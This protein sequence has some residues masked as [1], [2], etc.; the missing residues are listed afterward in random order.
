MAL[1]KNIRQPNSE[2]ISLL[3]KYE[4]EYLKEIRS[5][6]EIDQSS[7]KE[8]IKTKIEEGK[9]EKFESEHDYNSYI[10]GLNDEL[11][12]SFELKSSSKKL[13]IIGLYM[14]VEKY[15]KIIVKWLYTGLDKNE[16]AEK[17][18]N[19]HRWRFL[20]EEMNREKITLS[21]VA[22][23]SKI[24][25]LRCLNNDIKHN[26]YVGEELSNFSTWSNDINKEID[27]E[28][29]D[30]DNFYNSMPKYLS[31]LAEKIRNVRFK[32]NKSK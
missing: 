28:K 18:K 9:L 29:I 10:D 31:D 26:G 13:L 8:D 24:N 2:I 19:L 6:I 22:E 11:F 17:I 16:L 15:T 5:I 1:F 27:T 7:L 30:L 20:E 4:I 25:E 21:K 12:Q 3:A 14:I 23:Y 32:R